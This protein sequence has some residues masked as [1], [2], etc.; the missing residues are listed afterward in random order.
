MLSSLDASGSIS[1]F[2]FRVLGLGM[3]GIIASSGRCCE[4]SIMKYF[5]T[6]D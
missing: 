2:E 3:Y 6:V 5:E 1:G 4:T